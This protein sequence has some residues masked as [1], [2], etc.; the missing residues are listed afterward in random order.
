MK[1]KMKYLI[2][3]SLGL[4]CSCSNFLD[5][6]NFQNIPTEEAYTSV[7]DVENGMNGMYYAF[8]Y[9]YFYGRNTVALG[10]IAAD[11]AVA[12]ASTGH[13][14][15]INRYNFS[16][17]EE[18]LDNIWLGG[19]Q[20]LDRATRTIAGAKKL[21]NEK[22]ALHLSEKDMASLHSYISQCYALR[23]LAQHVLVNIFGLPYRA[24][25]ANTQLGI[26]LP[27]EEPVEPFTPVE[28]SSVEATYTHILSDIAEAGKWYT[29]VDNYN[30]NN[31]DDAI[32][33]DQFYMNR[34][35]I[36]ALEARVNLY[37]ERYARAAIAADSAVILR[38]AG[39]ISN[40]AYL[41]MW[42]STAISDEDIFTIAKSDDDNLSSNS[43]NVLYGSYKAALTDTLVNLFAPGDIR[44]RLI[45]VRTRH[46]KKFDGTPTSQSVNNIPVFRISEMKLIQAEA[47]AH[48]GDVA[49]ARNALFYTAKRNTAITSPADL[50]GS[51][52]GLLDFTVQER[53]RE[54]FEEGFRWYDA[55]RTGERIAVNG[56]SYRNFD[57]AAF[58]YPIPASEVN[59]GFGVVQNPDWASHL[60]G[61]RAQ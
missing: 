48:L 56:G 19:Y 46:P 10:D 5:L 20:V 11:N 27:G 32:L 37:M 15:A 13:F 44:L 59:A 7:Q 41:K 24:G 23:A 38:D 4:L 50:P 14:V 22:D 61:N 43:L 49:Q 51:V 2:G 58:V 39:E 6:D 1:N 33:L 26:V 55:R 3:L 34:A 54:L 16:D 12:D 18:V 60:P 9:Y 40:E 45:D 28:R 31:E 21:L 29:N 47:Y 53:R 42:S 30:L 17:T 36:Y 52:S 8:G 35:A 25:E 57:V